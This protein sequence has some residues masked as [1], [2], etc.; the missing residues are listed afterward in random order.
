[1]NCFSSWKVLFV[2][3]QRPSG[4]II[5][6]ID[7]EKVKG[8]HPQKVKKVK[9][10]LPLIIEEFAILSS[11]QYLYLTIKGTMKLYFMYYPRV[12]IV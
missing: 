7:K 3:Y 4:Y 11:K 10:S 12:V 1:M 6:T 2:S 8:L 5:I 9:K